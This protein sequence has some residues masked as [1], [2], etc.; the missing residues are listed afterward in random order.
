MSLFL[1]KLFYIKTKVNSGGTERLL[2]AIL[3]TSMKE[4]LE[5]S[6]TQVI[7]VRAITCGEDET[8]QSGNQRRNNCERNQAA[9]KQTDWKK[10]RNSEQRA[11]FIILINRH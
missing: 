10:Q 8:R 11:W 6:E 7:I 9:Q 4:M 1:M 5:K 2:E 3:K